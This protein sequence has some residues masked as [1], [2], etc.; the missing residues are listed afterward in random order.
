[1]LASFFV[2]SNKNHANRFNERRLLIF[3]NA[4]LIFH[5]KFLIFLK[6]ILVINKNNE[7]E[8]FE[9]VF[10]K[11]MNFNISFELH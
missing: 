2:Y 1:M 4:E 9:S 3:I 11:T 7:I 10:E 5:R 8:I 6:K